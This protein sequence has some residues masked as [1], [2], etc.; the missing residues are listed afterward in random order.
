V[1]SAVAV[2]A[3]DRGDLGLLADALVAKG[4]CCRR[5][6]RIDEGVAAMAE[7]IA[8]ATAAGDDSVRF[9][10]LINR[11]WL[12]LEHDPARAM[13]ATEAGIAV[14]RRLGVAS[15]ERL[16]STFLVE[17]GM[18]LGA[19][20]PID[21]LLATADLDRW[22]G[23]DALQVLSSAVALAAGR[24]DDPGLWQRRLDALDADPEMKRLYVLETSWD[25]AMAAER[26]DE[27]MR[28]GW[29]LAEQG[30]G[31]YLAAWLFAA[32][33]SLWAGD[34]AR[35]RSALERMPEA[36]RTARVLQPQVAALDAAAAAALGEEG[37][38]LG[39][40]LAAHAAVAGLG[41]RWRAALAALDAA[42]VFP[43]EPAVRPLLAEARDLFAEVG[44]HP[45]RERAE[46]LLGEP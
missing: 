4:T 15:M 24:G 14:A 23:S 19:W 2:Q 21:A 1:A 35:A 45:W 17:L 44:A 3:A 26:Y 6:G 22:E 41:L 39:P 28:A 27:A 7:G 31:F 37:D 30:E 36:G 9:R 12:L 43:G 38:H 20:A 29:A 5:T 10:G 25:I 33:G 46:Q 16:L 40:F 11:A 34:P 8:L 42:L 18:Q 13:E 32:R